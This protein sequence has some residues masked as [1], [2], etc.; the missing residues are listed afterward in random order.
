[1][2]FELPEMLLMIYYFNE[3]KRDGAYCK[4]GIAEEGGQ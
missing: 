3:E 4:R 2:G 1:M